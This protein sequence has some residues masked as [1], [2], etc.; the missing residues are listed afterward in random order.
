MGKLYLYLKAF[1]KI[2]GCGNPLKILIPVRCRTMLKCAQRILVSWQ[3]ADA[4]HHQIS[5]F[6]YKMGNRTN[7]IFYD[8]A[9]IGLWVERNLSLMNV[10]YL[11]TVY[12]LSQSSNWS[13]CWNEKVQERSYLLCSDYMG[14]SFGA[15][16]I[17]GWRSTGKRGVVLWGSEPAIK[18]GRRKSWINSFLHSMI[19]SELKVPN[20]H[21]GIRW[22]SC[23]EE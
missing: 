17:M 8:S 15:I 23:P 20:C 7:Q 9:W 1:S 22:S 13:A 10:R 3:V 11:P 14:S 18:A 21:A 19:L 6:Q 12:A 2:K 5:Y 16:L 4:I